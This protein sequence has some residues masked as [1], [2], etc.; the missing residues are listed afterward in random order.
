MRCHSVHAPRFRE[1]GSALRPRYGAPGAA[2]N[3]CRVGLALIGILCFAP[4][5][6]ASPVRIL[7]FGDSLVAGY[8]LAEEEA[9]P[10]RLQ[11]ALAAAG[12]EAEVINGGVSGDTTAG[13]LARLDWSL[14]DRPDV[15]LLEL[16]GNDGLRGIDPGDTEANLDA[17]LRKLAAREIPVL[18]VGMLAPPNLGPEFGEEF[19]ALFPRLA[20][21]H[22]VAFYPFFLDG[23]ARD[24][25]LNQAD[26]LHP[27]AAGV[28]VIVERILPAVLKVIGQARAAAAAG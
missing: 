3:V 23:V 7:A 12:V 26:G 21:R 5:A 18:F 15:V 10:A 14:A 25:A 20:A 17:M 11:A 27:N 16:G 28:E 1:G 4:L 8:G 9:F 13:G 2:V 22:K 6:S 19:N 24:P